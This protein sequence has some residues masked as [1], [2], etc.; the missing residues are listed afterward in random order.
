M[1]SEVADPGEARKLAERQERRAR[2]VAMRD[3]FTAGKGETPASRTRLE[4]ALRALWPAQ[5][6]GFRVSCRVSLCRVELPPPVAAS[7]AALE[8]DPGVRALADEV[9][10]D[11]DGVDPAGFVLLA[12]PG[13][14]AGDD[15]LGKVEQEFLRSDDARDCLSRVGAVG[16]VEYELRVDVS[17]ITYRSRT[18]L[19]RP[20]LECVDDVLNR[21][22]MS[23]EIPGDVKTSSRTFGLRR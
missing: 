1:P 23:T 19:P 5:P 17:G 9:F 13:A 7:Q 12:A 11:P 4:P 14:A 22:V 6:P 2:F 21:I 16:S 3:A 8:A 20:V 10:L 15:V 18:D